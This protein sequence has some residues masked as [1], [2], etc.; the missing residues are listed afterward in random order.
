MRTLLAVTLAGLLFAG[1]GPASP[2]TNG[3]AGEE[4]VIEVSPASDAQVDTSRIEELLEEIAANT[5]ATCENIAVLA[6]SDP[7]RNAKAI[8]GAGEVTACPGGR[9]FGQ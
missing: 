5:S 3:S 2:A 6:Y 9:V 8:W 7:N 1:C 4:V